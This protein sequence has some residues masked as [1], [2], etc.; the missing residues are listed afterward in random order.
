MA[1][2]KEVNQEVV[3]VEETPVVAEPVVETVKVEV[4]ADF[5]DLT[6][7][8]KLRTKGVVLEVTK[9][10]AEYLIKRGLVKLV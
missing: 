4:V 6:A 1:A 8:E 10:R 2:K 7:E 3:A 5:H 9:E